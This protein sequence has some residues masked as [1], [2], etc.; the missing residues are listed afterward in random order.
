MKDTKIRK[1]IERKIFRIFGY[2]KKNCR[3]TSFD[4]GEQIR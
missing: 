3:I 1:D 4:I 2:G